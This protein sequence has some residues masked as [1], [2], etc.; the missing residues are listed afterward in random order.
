[1]IKGTIESCAIAENL[2]Y[3]HISNQP[4]IDSFD[5]FVPQ[6]TVGKIIGRCGEQVMEISS[7]SGAKVNVV[8]G[9]RSEPTRKITLK[10]NK[11]VKQKS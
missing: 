11:E 5:M 3:E 4:V 6:S 7:V 1:M 2:I 10:G 9:D 8:E